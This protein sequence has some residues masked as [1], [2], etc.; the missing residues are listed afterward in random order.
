MSLEA[1]QG[2]AVRPI[3]RLDDLGFDEATDQ[4][5]LFDVGIARPLHEVPAVG[6][7]IEPTFGSQHGQCFAYR[8]STD[9]ELGRPW[10]LPH[11][12]TGHQL[13]P[14]ERSAQLCDCQPGSTLISGLAHDHGT[15]DR[16]AV[17]DMQDWRQ[18]CTIKRP[19]KGAVMAG[20]N[21]VH[22]LAISVADIEGPLEFFTQACGM[23]MKA[24]YWMHGVKDAYHIFLRLNDYSSLALVRDPAQDGCHLSD[25]QRDGVGMPLVT[26]NMQHVSFNLAT[27]DDLMALRDRIRAHGYQTFGPIDHGF[28]ES[29]YIPGVSERMMVEFSWS[30]SPLD[31]DRWIEQSCI[32]HAGLSAEQVDRYRNPNRTGAASSGGVQPDYD[33]SKQ[34]LPAWLVKTLSDPER[35]GPF[36]ASL[37]EAL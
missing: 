26:G 7:V 34:E 15:D 2:L 30:A 19:P 8:D 22:H 21:G 31:A 33:P 3:D 12:L 24:F 17:I 23:E 13:A 28:C 25:E 4:E 6:L 9:P 36:E 20:P 29:V 11:V 16:I 27:R 32:E 18:Y 5:D 14:F 10:L 1:R 35:L 37:D